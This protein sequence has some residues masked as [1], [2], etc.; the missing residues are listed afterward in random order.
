MGDFDITG[1]IAI[2]MSLIG[3]VTVWIRVGIDKGRQE[4]LTLALK[5]KTDKNEQGIAE[6]KG[7]THVIELRI[8]EF[9]G[10]IKARLDGIKETVD[11]LKPK[12]GRCA[13]EK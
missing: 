5:Q 12:R 6:L 9:M 13:E 7:K 4:E 10:E 8:A 1:F 11:E 2:A 3:F